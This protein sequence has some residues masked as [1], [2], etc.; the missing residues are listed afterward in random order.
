MVIVKNIKKDNNIISCDYVPEDS[1]YVGHIVVNLESEDIIEHKNSGFPG[2][3]FFKDDAYALHAKTKLL[4]ISD[5]KVFDEP[6]TVMW[7]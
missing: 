3:L 1:E 6:V 5:N 2:V 7:Y 4:E